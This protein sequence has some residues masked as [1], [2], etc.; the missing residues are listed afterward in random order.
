[1]DFLS[2]L[3]ASYWG[4]L[5]LSRLPCPGKL[6]PLGDFPLSKDIFCSRQLYGLIL[7]PVIMILI[8]LLIISYYRAYLTQFTFFVLIM[9]LRL[10]SLERLISNNKKQG[11]LTMLVFVVEGLNRVLLLVLD[12]FFANQ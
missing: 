6:H 5:F 1:M 8:S 11:F 4:F 3:Y 12:L 10:L 7:P 9:L 2:S